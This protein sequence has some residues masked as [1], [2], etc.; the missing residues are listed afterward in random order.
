MRLPAV[1]HLMDE[2][3]ILGELDGMPVPSA[4]FVTVH[5]AR[6]RDNRAVPYLEG[7]NDTV[8]IA[9]HRIRA[10]QVLPQGGTDNVIGFVRE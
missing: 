8:L 4:Q 7:P 5:H 3:P 1:I 2:D 9:W 10:V 6:R